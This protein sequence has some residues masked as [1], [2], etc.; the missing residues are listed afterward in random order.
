M[1][2][3]ELDKIGIY[4]SGLTDD[5]A[6][7]GLQ[8][9]GPNK[10][11]SGPS[12]NIIHIV[13]DI[14][15]EPMFLLLAF[16]CL[17]YF[18]LGEITEGL[19]MAAAIV[20]VTTISLYQEWRSSNAVKALQQYTAAGVLVLRGGEKKMIASE[21]LVP[22]DLILLE[23]GMLVPA[24]AEILQSND[25]A[26]NESIIT[27]ES[28][29]VEKNV[30]SDSS[31]LYQGTTINSGN[32]QA[33]VTATGN[34]TQLG[35]LGRAVSAASSPKTLLQVQMRRVVQRLALFGITGFLLVLLVNYSKT[36]EWAASLLLA[37]TL[38]MSAVP[39]EIPV[40]LSSFMALG[41][42][43]MSRLGIISRQPQIIENLGAVSVICLD[44][45]GTITEN[46]M[47]LAELYVWKD[48]Q[49][50]PADGIL[51][52]AAVSLLHRASLASETRPF[53]PMEIAIWEA[54]E[55]A[56]GSVS[57]RPKIEHEYPLQGRPPMM[58]H[59][60]SEDQHWLAASKGAVE[61]LV[62]AANL[63]EKES[64]EINQQAASMASKGYRVLAVAEAIHAGSELPA[65]QDDF[66]WHIAGL[67]ALYDP[68]K[69][70]ISEVFQQF[71]QAN[72]DLKLLTGDHPQTA[73]HI[74]AKAG[75]HGSSDY[76][77]GE[78]L[79]KLNDEE[80]AKAADRY[81]IYARMFPDA[82][83]KLVEFMQSRGEIV[84]MTGDGV[85]DGPALKVA[86]IGIAMGKK[87]TEIARR[88]ADLI[89]TD[90]DIGRMVLAIREGRK[91]FVNLK[92]AIRYII[93]IHIP[94]ILV[95]SL[96]LLLGWKYPT[97][98]TPIHVIFLELIMGPTC[99]IFFERE[100]AEPGI[101]KQLPRNRS[102]GLFSGQEWG[103]SVV[104]G[105][106]IAGGAFFLYY[107]FMR[108][109]SSLPVTRNIVFTMLL[110]SNILLTFSNRSDTESIFR[111]IRYR[112][113]L[114]PVVFVVSVGL[115]LL[116]QLAPTLR[117]LF[118][119]APISGKQFM[120]CALMAAVSVLWKE[121]YKVGLKALNR[122]D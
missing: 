33:R 96:P 53:D 46:R 51:S 119:L 39:E 38:A 21:E 10:F 26:V 37:L 49:Q 68:P 2:A 121:V 14:V 32:A 122:N 27:G 42:Y 74:A 63:S 29:P 112:N 106:V 16:A 23:E 109:G 57:E 110:L 15:R 44:K 100:P 3:N 93:S 28:L 1:Q 61:R 8:K 30:G 108:E 45:T 47:K 87:G 12:R 50:F 118:Q 70:N 59:L 116:L 60:F 85:N 34:R 19:M 67:L 80:L 55:A 36:N 56:R 92:K 113:S 103:M 41:A 91:I 62:K 71:Y 25:L 6:K 90:D 101:M 17:L 35:K 84:A 82:K 104:Q 75:M 48:R 18:I 102:G 111:T 20:I 81:S 88:A 31:F 95:A 79:M 105:L 66:D 24:D 54:Y 77:T 97:V 22:G 65:M 114:A 43:K 120:F 86:S 76:I 89:I 64:A 99:S 7:Q 13:L 69:A 5:E 98:F 58:T 83:K 107:F 11:E 117:E 115:I 4:R 73:M 72:I 78:E 94:I 40:A 9:W 52:E